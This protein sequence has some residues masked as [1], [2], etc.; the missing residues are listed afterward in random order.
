M[1]ARRPEDHEGG[2]AAIPPRE[3]PADHAP[4]DRADGGSF[5]VFGNSVAQCVD[6]AC[7]QN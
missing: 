3:S 7:E 6:E 1:F 2:A 4:L 5:G